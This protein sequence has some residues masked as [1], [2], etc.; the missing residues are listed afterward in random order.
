MGGLFPRH[1]GRI[2]SVSADHLRLLFGSELVEGMQVVELQ[3]STELT[4]EG[5]I[6]FRRSRRVEMKPA[7]RLP[8][9]SLGLIFGLLAVV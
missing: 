5:A 1:S 6:R 9:A 3:D 4:P 2:L 8:A 7:V